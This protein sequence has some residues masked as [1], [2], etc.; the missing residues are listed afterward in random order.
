MTGSLELLELKFGDVMNILEGFGCW[1]CREDV[2][3][4]HAGM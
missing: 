3:H 4:G 2:A 1:Y